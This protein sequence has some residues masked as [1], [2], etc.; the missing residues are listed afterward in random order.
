MST[1]SQRTSILALL[2]LCTQF[3]T[4]WSVVD[5]NDATP[6]ASPVASP[7]A[8]EQW[9]S[10]IQIG[11]ND[12]ILARAVRAETCPQITIDG[13]TGAMN[14]RALPNV[15]HPNIVCE[16]AVPTGSKSVAIDGQAMRLP[17][18]DPQRI[19]LIGDTGCRLKAPDAFQACNDPAEWPFARTAAASTV[20]NP[21]LVIHVGDYLYR[22]SPCPDG[23]TG[24]A[25][26]PYGD[27]WV[28]WNADF[29]APAAPLL[30]AAPWI[31]VRGNHEDCTREGMG[32]FRYLDP[33]P[34]PTACQTYTEP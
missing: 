8:V 3:L 2:L 12:V 20:W 13:S 15:D 32:W 27:N 18:A 19:A 11:P 25:G 24:C 7:A 4:G 16:T 5:A 22:E 6:A 30:A 33:M 31:L 17:V 26:S 34:M 10:W 29:F 14:I 1:R 23:N 28:T 9:P 21:D